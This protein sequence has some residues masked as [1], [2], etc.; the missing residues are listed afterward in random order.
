MVTKFREYEADDKDISE[1]SFD[2]THRC[3]DF[4]ISKEAGGVRRAIRKSFTAN[5][6]ENHLEIHLVWA[7]L[8]GMEPKLKTFSYV[9]LRSATKDFNP[10]NKLGEGGF[11]LVYKGVLSDGRMIVVKQLSLGSHQG[12][13]QFI[14]EIASITVVQHRNLVKL[15]GCYIE[16]TRCLLVYEYHE[17]N[18]LD[19]VYFVVIWHKYAMRGHLTDKADVFSFGVVALEIISGRAN[20]YSNLDREKTYLLE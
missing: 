20:S 14:N 6:T 16:G 10:S 2:G 12:K 1:A 5:V 18:N 19:K 7:V 15:Y 3:K 4:D 17:N 11:G 8:L 13:N 9:E